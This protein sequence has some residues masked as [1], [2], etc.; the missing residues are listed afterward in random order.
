MS[1]NRYFIMNSAPPAT[2]ADAT[3]RLSDSCTD[4]A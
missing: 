4:P 3:N 1:I 2:S